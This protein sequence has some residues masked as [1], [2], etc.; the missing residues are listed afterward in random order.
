MTK[1]VRAIVLDCDAE[2]CN[3]GF[4]GQTHPQV[5]LNVAESA[6]MT[7]WSEMEKIWRRVFE[8]LKVNPAEHPVLLTEEITNPRDS[9]EKMTQI[10]FETFHVPALY[11]AVQPV[12]SLYSSG[13]THGLAVELRNRSSHMVPV[14]NGYAIANKNTELDC[15][16]DGLSEA[17]YKSIM[18]CDE[19]VR[20]CLYEN[21][22][23]SGGASLA[24]GFAEKLTKDLVALSG[25][26]NVE[27]IVSEHRV[28]GSWIGGS[29]LTALPPFQGMAISKEEYSESGPS[30]V[31]HKCPQNT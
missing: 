11:I 7:D 6:H 5:V 22:V 20:C 27:V 21:I 2:T 25:Y 13:R 19:E 26:E 30:I 24:D 3:A 12:L 17:I 18:N 16:C 29:I 4:A 1:R 23:L 9:R 28:C 10:M 15:G 14:Y 31:H 8:E